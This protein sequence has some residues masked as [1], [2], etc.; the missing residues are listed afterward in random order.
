MKFS[1]LLQKRREEI[2]DKTSDF[3]FLY[4]TLHRGYHCQMA[5]ITHEI[6][7]SKG[8]PPVLLFLSRNNG[9]TQRE[10][11]DFLQIKPASMTDVLQR[12]E[13]NELVERKRGKKDQR[14]MHVFI[15]EK[16]KK[17]VEEFLER[18]NALDI[19]FFKG[20]TREEKENFLYSFLKITENL[21]MENDCCW[22]VEK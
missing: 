22:E 3:F 14:T 15:T 10:L 1:G 7:L 20:F 21:M 17:K 4:H 16:G 11:S 18:E 5:K 9:K 19:L 13:K 12:M 6:G 2:G 8:Q